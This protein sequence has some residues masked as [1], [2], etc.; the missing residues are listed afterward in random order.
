MILE[1]VIKYTVT[2]NFVHNG[3]LRVLVRI[4]YLFYTFHRNKQNWTEATQQFQQLNIHLTFPWTT[5][6]Y[7]KKWSGVSHKRKMT[8]NIYYLRGSIRS[9]AEVLQ[10][11]YI[12]QQSEI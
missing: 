6:V 11:L 1:I 5:N 12:Q 3:L 2:Y 8:W 9:T 7:A 10:W 4:M